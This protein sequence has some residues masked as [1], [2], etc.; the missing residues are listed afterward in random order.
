MNANIKSKEVVVA[1]KVCSFYA[2]LCIVTIGCDLCAI[3]L[4]SVR[5]S[6]QFLVSK[7]NYKSTKET[8]AI[9]KSVAAFPTLS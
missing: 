9:R 7:A 1:S 2:A 8:C 4:R 6:D 5:K 3:L